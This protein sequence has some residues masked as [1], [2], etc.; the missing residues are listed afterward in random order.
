MVIEKDISNFLNTVKNDR[1]ISKVL[2]CIKDYSNDLYEHSIRVGIVSAILGSYMGVDAYEIFLCGLFHDYGKVLIDKRILEKPGK[3]TDK[4]RGIMMQ[5]P[6]LGYIELKQLNIFSEQV[7]LGIL[8]H[9]E[10]VDGKGYSFGK[11]GT[12]I[13]EFGKIVSVADVYCAMRYARPYRPWG[14]SVDV[15]KEE[16]SHN[17]GGSFDSLVVKKFAMINLEIVE[18]ILERDRNV[19]GKI[20]RM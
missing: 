19:R 13:S 7:L 17:S 18:E 9:H 2:I 10:R 14:I 11:K 8:D 1:Y 3:L 20:A 15:I 4:E 16:F 12:E 6:F 5:H